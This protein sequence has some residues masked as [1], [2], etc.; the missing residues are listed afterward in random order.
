MD[1]LVLKM[2]FLIRLVIAVL[3]GGILGLERELRRKEAGLRT[4]SLVCLGATLFTIVA[5]QSFK[6]FGIQGAFDPSRIVGQLV[7]GIG[8]LGAGLI[9]FKENR[10]EGLTTA[11]GLWVTTA[12]GTAIGFGLYTL[13]FLTTL[14]AI[15]IFI[16]FRWIERE[17][18]KAK[19]GSSR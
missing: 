13:A 18:L 9:I 16:I 19:T 4:Y 15:V 17:V 8:F 2:E 3:L 1:F 11:A 12:I 7:L 5:I 14:L 10:I 6:F